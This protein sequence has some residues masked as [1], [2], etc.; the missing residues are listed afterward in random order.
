MKRK[1]GGGGEKDEVKRRG[2]GEEERGSTELACT[3]RLVHA[4]RRCQALTGSGFVLQRKN[5]DI[6]DILSSSGWIQL[7]N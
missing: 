2:G 3:R 7:R 5:C 1:G 6:M 4:M